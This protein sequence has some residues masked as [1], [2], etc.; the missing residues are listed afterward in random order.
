MHFTFENSPLTSFL[1]TGI[2]TFATIR[3]QSKRGGD[4]NDQEVYEEQ[5]VASYGGSLLDRYS[6]IC[7]LYR[8]CASCD[9]G[10]VPDSI[11]V[12]VSVRDN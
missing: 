4:P 12:H 2:I 1:N 5:M 8:V 10:M 6:G 9:H 3:P 7:R 11:V